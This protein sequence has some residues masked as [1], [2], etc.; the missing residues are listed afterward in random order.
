MNPQ[1]LNTKNISAVQV[2]GKLLLKLNFIF[3]RY[4]NRENH[5]GPLSLISNYG[6]LL[7]ENGCTVL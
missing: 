5:K 6:H 1:A 2:F 7:A 4:H 3:L